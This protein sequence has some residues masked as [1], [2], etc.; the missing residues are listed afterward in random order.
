MKGIDVGARLQEEGRTQAAFARHMG[1]SPW[2][3]NRLVRSPRQLTPSEVARVEDFFGDGPPPEPT[4]QRVPVFGFAAAQ[5]DD[6]IAFAPDSV[7][8]YVDVPTG[9]TRGE[10]IAVRVRGDS[11]EPRLFSGETLIVGLNVSPNRFGDC[12][13]E[14]RDNTIMVKQYRGQRDGRVH[15][16]QYNPERE[17][18]LDGSRIRAVHAVLLR[19]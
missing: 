2:A 7:M 10:T 15:L 11:M 14:L 19:R 17:I 16:Y 4:L 5:N 6:Y 13:V 3:A 1:V 8:D 18:S 9:L 12:V